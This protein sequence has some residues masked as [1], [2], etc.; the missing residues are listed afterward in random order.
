M[1]ET[2]TGADA[3][4]QRS[5]PLR[6]NAQINDFYGYAIGKAV[7]A[8]TAPFQNATKMPPPET[9]AV[10]SYTFQDRDGNER[11]TRPQPARAYGP[12]KAQF[13]R[14]YAETKGIE[15]P[16]FVSQRKAV[17]LMRAEGETGHLKVAQKGAKFIEIPRNRSAANMPTMLTED[18]P[19]HDKDGNP[20]EGKK[21]DAVRD[22][23]GKSVMTAVQFGPMADDPPL[24]VVAEGPDWER[25]QQQSRPN[26][27]LPL[28]ESNAKAAPI[29][30]PTPEESRAA[31]DAMVDTAQKKWG[32]EIRGDLEPGERSTFEVEVGDDGKDRSVIHLAPDASQEDAAARDTSLVVAVSHACAYEQAKRDPGARPDPI[33]I[34][35]AGEQ[36][37]ETGAFAREDMVANIAA[38]EFMTGAGLEFKP[39]PK[40][41]T[42]HLREAQAHALSQ[43]GGYEQVTYNA[44]RT[45]R[46]LHG[47]EPTQRDQARV[48]RQERFQE[49]LAGSEIERAAAGLPMDTELTHDA[50]DDLGEDRPAPQTGATP[51]QA[52]S[53]DRGADQPGG[54][55]G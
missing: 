23:N 35:K 3:P 18:G 29:A 49:R 1:A 22:E 16:Q 17:Q 13:L 6:T 28:S 2:D 14:A 40:E 5:K 11:T 36:G 27:I 47:N 19:N 53:R 30:R 46:M 31:L 39:Q 21:G 54:G 7:M 25:F 48:Q 44:A 43:P 12:A 24:N 4:R 34:Q 15:N 20:V 45:M 33:D 38:Q 32:I 10:P 9:P 41:E 50:G 42:E 52:Q 37:R 51:E 55:P 26:R 8:G